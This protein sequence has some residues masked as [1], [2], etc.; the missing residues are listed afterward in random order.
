M[1]ARL[2]ICR[3]W[4]PLQAANERLE[5][6]LVE[7]TRNSTA[8]G[9]SPA[10]E[11]SAAGS[12][13]DLVA[14]LQAQLAVASGRLAAADERVAQLEKL[15]KARPACWKF[16]SAWRGKGCWG[17]LYMHAR[18]T[19]QLDCAIYALDGLGLIALHGAVLPTAAGG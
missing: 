3:I 11:P 13:A 2:W 15:L 6:A 4:R 19:S 8:G 17:C 7:A 9:A 12:E 1:A 5:M 14:E 16:N 18:M 10:A